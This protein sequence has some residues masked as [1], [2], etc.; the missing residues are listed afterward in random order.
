MEPEEYAKELY[1][2]FTSYAPL[3]SDNKKCA[4]IAINEIRSWIDILDD[5]SIEF[6]EETKKEIKK[7]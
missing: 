6:V 1:Y 2:K 4:L 7:L 5:D 3:H